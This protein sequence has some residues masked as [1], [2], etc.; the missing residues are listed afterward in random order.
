M[1]RARIA[2]LAVSSALIA[3]LSA[4]TMST[5]SAAPSISPR[6]DSGLFGAQDPTYDGVFRQASA[7]S[8]LVTAQARVPRAAVTWLLGQQCADGSFMA[9]RADINEPCPPSDPATYSG[10]DTN[11]TALAVAA[12]MAVGEKSAANRAATW[13]LRQQ[14]SG[15]GFPYYAGGTPDSNST[16]LALAAL[17]FIDG[18]AKAR[19]SA[20][21]FERRLAFGCD[22]ERD[23]V[24]GMPYMAGMLPDPISASQALFGLAGALP[25]VP[26]DQRRGAP[27]VTC[28]ANN[29]VENAKAATAHWIARSLQSHDGA[30]PDAF[31]P[32]AKDWNST[33][34]SIIGLVAARTAGKA[35][36]LAINALADN[37][38]AYVGSDSGDRPAAL[39]ISILAAVATG[40]DPRN[41][42]G[43]DL[44][45]DLQATRR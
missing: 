4:G 3:G 32:T 31:D 6:G 36:D 11:S 28:D 27:T 19:K 17:K 26:R 34:V 40:S 45:A 39:G 35:T 15:G 20:S 22:A 41:F 8:A 2:A 43:R 14:T 29:R 21:N 16:G 7:L 25:A 10:P 33:A 24:G 30:L 23:V 18:T 38:E 12:L 37:I 1:L 42:G 9:Y 44:V 5:S 13:L